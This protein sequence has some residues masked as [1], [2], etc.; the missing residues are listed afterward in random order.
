MV[1][2]CVKSFRHVGSLI[3]VALLF[4]LVALSSV[5][6]QGTF[7]NLDFESAAV[8]PLPPGQYGQ[9]LGISTS[10]GIPFWRVYYGSSESTLMSQN[11]FT[12]GSANVS[13]LGPS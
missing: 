3:A 7:R 6:A 11:T 13:I 12:G 9:F 2:R 1:K 10:Q 8:A 5:L 4:G